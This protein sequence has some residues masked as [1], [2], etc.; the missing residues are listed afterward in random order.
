MGGCLRADGFAATDLGRQIFIP[1]GAAGAS[2][3]P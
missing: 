1:A 3:Y 2:G